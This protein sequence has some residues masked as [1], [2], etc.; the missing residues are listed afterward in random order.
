MGYYH[1][2][3]KQMNGRRLEVLHTHTKKKKKKKEKTNRRGFGFEGILSQLG[4]NIYIYIYIYIFSLVVV[5]YI[6]GLC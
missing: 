6:N 3:M 5:L 4:G 2:S 1:L